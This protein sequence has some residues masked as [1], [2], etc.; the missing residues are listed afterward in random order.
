MGG[1]SSSG[2]GAP[3]FFFICSTTLAHSLACASTGSRRALRVTGGA[4]RR[5]LFLAGRFGQTSPRTGGRGCAPRNGRGLRGLPHNRVPAHSRRTSASLLARSPPRD[6]LHH[7]AHVTTAVPARRASLRLSGDAGR[8]REDRGLARARRRPRARPAEGI[9]PSSASDIRLRQVAPA[10][11][12]PRSRAMSLPPSKAMPSTAHGLPTGSSYVRDGMHD[13]RARVRPLDG[14]GVR[15]AGPASPRRQREP[16]GPVRLGHPVAVGGAFEDADAIE[17][18][19]PVHGRSM[20]EHDG[21][22]GRP[23]SMGSG[24]SFIAEAT[25]ASSRD[26]WSVASDFTNAGT[27]SSGAFWSPAKVASTAPAFVPARSKSIA[28]GEPPSTWRSRARP[29]P[30]ARPSPAAKR[31]SASAPSIVDGETT[32]RGACAARSSRERERA[33]AWTSI[34][35]RKLRRSIDIGGGRRGAGERT[36]AS[37]GARSERKWSTRSRG[38]EGDR[39]GEWGPPPSPDKRPRVTE[40]PSPGVRRPKTRSPRRPRP[41]KSRRR[42]T[43][44]EPTTASSAR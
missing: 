35:K 8:T 23:F 14:H 21:P 38:S 17:R 43:R 16:R 37:F 15:C 18:L 12:T 25:S 22:E 32:S 2:T 40:R 10:S 27:L 3:Q 5:V 7:V 20:P 41:R 44:A 31:A 28:K 1:V 36:R 4:H 29:A 24:A 26:A 9:L 11:V 33:L 6:F 34:D 42:F 30:V 13:Q 39:C 19:R